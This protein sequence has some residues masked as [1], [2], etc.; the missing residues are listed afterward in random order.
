MALQRLQEAAEKAKIELSTTQSDP[1]QPPVRHGRPSQGPTPPRLQPEARSEFQK[2]TEEPGRGPGANAPS[3]PFESGSSTMPGSRRPRTSSDDH[4]R[5]WHPPACPS[6]PSTSCQRASS[7]N[8]PHKGVNPDEV[9]A[10]G[11]TIQAGVLQGRRQGRPPARRHPALARH[12]DA[13][14]AIMTRLIDRNT[15]IP[16]KKSRGLHHCGR[17]PALRWTIHVLQGEREMA[18]VQ[19]DCSESSSSS[20][21]RPRTARCMPQIEVTFD[22]DA[23]GIVHVVGQGHGYGQGAESITHP[24]LGQSSL[25]PGRHRP[26]GQ[27]RRIPRR[28]RQ[29]AP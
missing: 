9:V 15:T 1:D 8:D 21:Y 28:G 18:A 3:T 27:G 25:G 14:A 29:E 26:D 17:Q 23:N 4:P 20:T 6:H 2:L 10:V 13:R 24:G 5:G 22:I 7:G 19:Q 16:T 11:A 12:R